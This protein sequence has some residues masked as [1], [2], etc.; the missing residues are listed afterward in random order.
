MVG[1]III[2]D[3]SPNSTYRH[4]ASLLT[5]YIY[6]A[7]IIIIPAVVFINC[8]SIHKCPKKAN[9]IVNNHTKKNWTFNL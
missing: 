3:D 9:I 5:Y 2:F 4:R 8:F 7:P 6:N 1:N